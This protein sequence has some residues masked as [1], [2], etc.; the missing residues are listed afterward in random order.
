[1][2]EIKHM[3]NDT[4]VC[5]YEHKNQYIKGSF[6]KEKPKVG[7]YLFLYNGRRKHLITG[8]ISNKDATISSDCTYNPSKA[9]FEL[10]VKYIPE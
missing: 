3:Y 2:A 9:L 4:S 1:M 6:F 10:N 7:D 8:I 5:I